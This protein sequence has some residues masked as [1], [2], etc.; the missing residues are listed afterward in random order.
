M[1]R[2]RGFAYD[3]AEGFVGEGGVFGIMD[4]DLEWTGVKEEDSDVDDDAEVDDDRE[5]PL[6]VK[7]SSEL[8]DALRPLWGKYL[9]F[10]KEAGD[11]GRRRI[12]SIFATE[13]SGRGEVS[14]IR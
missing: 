8:D 14:S 12:C 7:E 5:E 6:E 2:L 3:C 4:E 1:R 11:T 13:R 10:V 9:E